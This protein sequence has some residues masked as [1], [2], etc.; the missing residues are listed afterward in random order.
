MGTASGLFSA[1]TPTRNRSSIGLIPC[2]FRSNGRVLCSNGEIQQASG[3]S[4]GGSRM[5]RFVY[6]GCK[7][8]GTGSATPKLQVSND[9]LVKFIETSD[10]WISSRTGI[11]NR[12]ILSGNE[13]LM[14]LAVEAATKALDMAAVEP[15]DVDLVLLCSSTPDDLFGNATQVQKALG[16]WKNPP[17]YDIRAACSGFMLGLVSAA[18]HV[19]GGGFRNVL[20]IGADT[21]SRFLDWTDRGVCILFGDGAGAVLVQGC[22]IEEDGLF[23]FDVHSDGEGIKNINAP[24]KYNKMNGK[25]GS[26]GSPMDFPP[27]FAF[28]SHVNMNGKEVF[29]FA[30]RTVPIS[31]ETALKRAGM[32]R[33][34][35][36]WLLLHQAN[37]RIIDAVAT[38]LELPTERVISNIANYGN[39]SAASIPLALDEAVRAG[40][41]LPGQI[42]AA[43]GFGAGLTWASAIVR[44][45]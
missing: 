25:V 28:Y 7:L 43:S 34:S 15:D 41:V 11:R 37:Q 12:H 38:R 4:S 24:L 16:C 8:V 13:S 45:K 36:D 27:K 39:T 19:R 18:C 21:L 10:D 22:D 6:Q 40:K 17:A 29:R 42:L 20:V 26:E 44:W 35:I 9:D 14:A 32:S 30:S 1:S 2:G 3:V 5:N 31:I 33:S 23:G